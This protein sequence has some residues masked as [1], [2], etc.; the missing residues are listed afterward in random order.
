MF[1]NAM[2]TLDTNNT[3]ASNLLQVQHKW[4][5]TQSEL[6]QYIF[7]V[8]QKYK[9]IKY[10]NHDKYESRTTRD[11]LLLDM[12]TDSVPDTMYEFSRVSTLS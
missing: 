6:Y 10:R 4:T 3:Q 1:W 8:N 9:W 11:C 5:W 12:G 7:W 2:P